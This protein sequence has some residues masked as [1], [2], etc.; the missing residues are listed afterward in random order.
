M[1]RGTSV[2][3]ALKAGGSDRFHFCR[4]K[5]KQKQKQPTFVLFFRSQ[6]GEGHSQCAWPFT[7]MQVAPKLHTNSSHEL[8]ASGPMKKRK[9]KKI[10]IVS[11]SEHSYKRK[12]DN[13]VK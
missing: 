2:S 1:E 5:K 11:Y 3:A 10:S 12:T 9:K 4:L 13:N 6:S 7:S 8:G